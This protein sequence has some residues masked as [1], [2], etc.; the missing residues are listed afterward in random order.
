[1]FL[2]RPVKITPIELTITGIST[3]DRTCDGTVDVA[4]KGGTLN[5][6]LD[7]DDVSFVLANGVVADRFDGTDKAVI[8]QIK[9]AGEAAGNYVLV[10]PDDFKVTIICGAAKVEVKQ[11]TYTEAGNKEHWHCSDCGRYYVDAD[12]KTEITKE[13]VEISPIEHSYDMAAWKS[14]DT[15]HW[16]ECFCGD[17]TDAAS[18]IFK[19]VIDKVAT[20]TEKGLKHGECDICGYRKAA[21]EFPAIDPEKPGPTADSSH[22]VF[23]GVLL[24]LALGVLAG[25]VV[26]RKKSRA[27]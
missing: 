23:E 12:L 4:L 10:Q 22:A 7:D 16:H 6:V 2:I 15:E 20:E 8:T 19:E 18:H 1:M 14:N 26:Q 21:V 27:N 3:Q 13:A 17:K 5:G 24:M 25:G 9:L 11:P